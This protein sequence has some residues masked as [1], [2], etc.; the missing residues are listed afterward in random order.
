MD[1]PP[2]T[3]FVIQYRQGAVKLFLHF[4]IPMCRKEKDRHSKDAPPSPIP[5]SR[6]RKRPCL[7]Q[8]L[9]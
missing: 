9:H 4:R 8:G 2:Y 3:L 7:W 6:K 1:N 5:P